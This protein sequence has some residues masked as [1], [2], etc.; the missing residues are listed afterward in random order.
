MRLND[1]VSTNSCCADAAAD[2]LRRGVD[3]RRLAVTVTASVSPPTSSLSSTCAVRADLEA[4]VALRVL[5]EAGQLGRDFVHARRHRAHQER[6]VRAGDRFAEQAAFL[7]THDDGDAGQHR[8]LLV[9]DPTA[10]IRRA[11]LGESKVTD[12]EETKEQQSNTPQH[13]TSNYW[14]TCDHKRHESLRTTTGETLPPCGQSVKEQFDTLWSMRRGLF[15]LLFAVSGAAALI[16]EVVWTRLLTLHLGHGLAAASAV[17]AAFMGGLAAG[18][19]AAGRMAGRLSPSRALRTYAGLEIAI[20]VLALLMPLALLAVRPLLAAA[21]A[22]GTGG[23]S[24]ALLRLATSVLLLCVP[25][26]C[27][28]AT[29]PIAS[30]WMVR[31][32]STAAA[33]RRRVVCGQHARR[34]GRRGARRFRPDPRARTE[35]VDVRRRGVEPDRGGRRVADRA[36]HADRDVEA[37]LQSAEA[38]RGGT[39]VPRPRKLARPLKS[40]S[41]GSKSRS[42][43]GIA[44]LARRHRPWRQRL[45]IVDA[46]SGLDAPARSDPRAHHLRVQHRRGDLHHRSRRWRRDRFAAGVAHEPGHRPRVRPADQ[47]RPR[48]RRGVGRGL[49]AADHRRRSCRVPTISS[50]TCC[51]AKCCW[52]RRCC[53]R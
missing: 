19:G 31:M 43:S 37:G 34:R 52:C 39:S 14:G 2:L 46:A 18:A 42:D 23:G 5:L 20:A 41:H 22:D 8:A 27:M 49:G 35:R 17:L 33:R 38:R 47:R 40:R 26:A 44:P 28:G 7:V 24:F 15:L 36:A 12:N 21:Y 4:H 6:A 30:R 51:S 16:Y 45:R 1:G 3:E 11:L 10:Q 9:D 48:A 50:P 32:A 13:G 29:F 53:C 25:A